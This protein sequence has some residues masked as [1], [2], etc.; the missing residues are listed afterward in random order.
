MSEREK[1]RVLAA[2]VAAALGTLVV[3]TGSPS[4]AWTELVL[5]VCMVV[6]VFIAYLTGTYLY[7]WARERP[8]VA[9][10]W[11]AGA[12]LTPLS[13]AALQLTIGPWRR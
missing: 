12:A 9:F 3:A 8:P 6:L 7:S 5:L 4:G 1:T 13:A 2:Y 10:A 11:Y